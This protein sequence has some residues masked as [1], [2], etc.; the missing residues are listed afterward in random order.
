M[1]G[2]N[3]GQTAMVIVWVILVLVVAGGAGTFYL[4]HRRRARV[5]QKDQMQRPAS[6]STSSRRMSRAARARRS[7]GE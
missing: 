3:S 5:S 1:G 4:G 7:A 6:E 2:S